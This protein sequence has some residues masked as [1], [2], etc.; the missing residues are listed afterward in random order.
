MFEAFFGERGRK[1][2]NLFVS[3]FQLLGNEETVKLITARLI[4]TV[5]CHLLVLF[6]LFSLTYDYHAGLGILGLFVLLLFIY[7]YSFLFHLNKRA[8]QTWVA[9]GKLTGS[10]TPII[11][12]QKVAKERKWPLRM[13][14][15]VEIALAKANSSESNNNGVLGFLI[16][17]ALAALEGLYDVAESYLLPA[18]IIERLPIK[19]AAGKLRQLKQNVPEAL[20]GAFGMDV[21][22]GVVSAML[23]ALYFGILL[24]AGIASYLLPPYIPIE[25]VTTFNANQGTPF[26]LYLLPL[27]VA[28]VLI[29]LMHSIIKIL[30]SSLKATY[31]AVFYTAVNR[32]HQ[33]SPGMQEKVVRYLRL[34]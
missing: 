27:Y 32:P 12:A 25:W 9:Y 24:I 29:S 21:F 28:G 8:C 14:A 33:L 5:V 7:P 16:A 3:S 11:E 6:V 23:M 17:A 10:D 15:V 19:D 13:F 30:V 22:G 20:A 18:I 1:I 2:G 34:E 4:F 31:F 26:F